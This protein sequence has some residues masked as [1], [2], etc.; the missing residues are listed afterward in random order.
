MSAVFTDEGCLELLKYC[1]NALSQGD[2]K[3]RLFVN[4]YTPVLT[5]VLADLTQ[6]T[7]T[8]Y[9]AITLA[10][11]TW[12]FATASDIVTASYAGQTFTFSGTGQ[13]VYGYYVTNNA[14]TKCLWAER[15]GTAYVIPGGGGSLTIIPTV[16]DK[17]CQ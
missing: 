1:L 17:D 13:T 14:G 7:A 6:C 15:I 8:G 16:A 11:G 12:T 5:T 4:D 10:G 9:A 2:L 3:L